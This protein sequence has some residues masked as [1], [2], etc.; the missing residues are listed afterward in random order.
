ML[1]QTAQVKT[2]T[3]QNLEELAV[4]EAKPKS[5]TPGKMKM[6]EMMKWS[7]QKKTKTVKSHFKCYRY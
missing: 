4:S 6:I 5:S 2:K 3:E 7:L 1:R